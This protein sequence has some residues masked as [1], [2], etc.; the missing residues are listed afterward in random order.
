MGFVYGM[1]VLQYFKPYGLWV[2]LMLFG[3][4]TATATRYGIC[5]WHDCSTIL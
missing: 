5:V 1:I 2:D 4:N 3:Y